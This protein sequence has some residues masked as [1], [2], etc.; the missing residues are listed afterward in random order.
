MYLSL[1]RLN[2][3]SNEV[4]RDIRDADC[5]HRTVLKAFPNIFDPEAK[6]RAYYG[7]LHRLEFSRN[8][9][10]Q[11]YV[12]SQAEPSWGFLPPDY[13]LP[14]NGMP[15][16]ITKTVGE[17][18]SHLKAGRTLRFRL[19]ANPTRKIDTKSGLDGKKKNGKRV[20]LRKMDE[21]IQWLVRKAENNG[22]VLHHVA[23]AASGSAE[24]VK[25]GS[26]K[27]FQGVVYEGI[28]EIKDAQQFIHALEIGI[29]PGKSYGF[30]LL[31]IA[32]N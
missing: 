21:Q 25:C 24:L 14:S 30:G 6:A 13:L 32:P 5:F 17:A 11:L 26:I 18:Y 3:A 1:L 28:L 9:G 29:G 23:V 10:W 2:P 7:V 27:T 22:F 12:Q 19:R 16:P 15:N 31:S 8:N 20:P 4:Q